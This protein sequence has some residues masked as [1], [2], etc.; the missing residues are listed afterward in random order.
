V[1]FL[2]AYAQHQNLHIYF[3]CRVFFA[4]WQESC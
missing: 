1:V 3:L 4:P 2:C